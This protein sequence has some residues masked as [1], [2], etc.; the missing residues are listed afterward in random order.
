MPFSKILEKG[1]LF[2][3]IKFNQKRYVIR[4]KTLKMILFFIGKFLNSKIRYIMFKM[5]C[6]RS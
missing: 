2:V 3:K 5:R 1:F 6:L 4:K